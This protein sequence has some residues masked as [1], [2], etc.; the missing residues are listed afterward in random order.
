MLI[1][2]FG[3]LETAIEAVRAGRVRLRQQ[4]VQHRRDQ[5]HR[6]SRAG[7][8]GAGGVGATAAQRTRVA[9][10]GL[11]GRSAPML[12]VYKQIA[13]AADSS[14]PV[15]IQGESGT[16]KELVARAIHSHGRRS[17]RPFVAVNCGAIAETLLDS[18]LFGHARGAFTGAIADRRG[19]VRAGRRRHDVP[20]RDRR[21]VTRAAGQAAARARGVAKFARS[22]QH[23]VLSV[24]GAD[25]RRDQRRSRAGGGRGPLPPGSLLPPRR[26]RHRGAAAARAACRHP[27]AHCTLSRERRARAPDAAST[28]A[29]E[30]LEALTAIRAGPETSA[31]SRTRSSG[32]C[33]FSRGDVIEVADLPAGHPIARPGA[34][35]RTVHRPADARRART[36]IPDAR[37]EGRGRKP[38]P[39]RRRSWA[40]IGERSIGWPSASGSSCATDDAVR[41]A[42]CAIRC[43]QA[44]CIPRFRTSVPETRYLVRKASMNVE[45]AVLF[46]APRI[47]HRVAQLHQSRDVTR[48]IHAFS[49]PSGPPP[50]R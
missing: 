8:G 32:W 34:R 18:E 19:L 28:I 44:R 1:S 33:V 14:V 38:Q 31:S 48:V 47:A 21:D 29:P 6:R 40:S 7:A 20:R 12:E 2:G 27:A 23:G 36:S 10:E 45:P 39:R 37:A 3:T 41:V 43:S 26:H 11:L 24:A 4:A 16:G 13:R 42:L 50:K 5:G 35:G 46:R 17:S 22:A 15:L 49:V 30:A 25:H 9:P